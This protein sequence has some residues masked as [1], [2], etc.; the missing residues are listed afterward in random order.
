MYI[1]ICMYVYLCLLEC[2]DVAWPRGALTVRI[3]PIYFYVSIYIYIY[4]YIDR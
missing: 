4:I 3:Y 2:A 1:Y